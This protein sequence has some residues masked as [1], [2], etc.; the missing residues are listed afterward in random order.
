MKGIIYALNQYFI[1]SLD[2]HAQGRQDII[3]S[4]RESFILSQSV[5]SF[6]LL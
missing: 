3:L 1:L 5:I 2:A 6:L 4:D